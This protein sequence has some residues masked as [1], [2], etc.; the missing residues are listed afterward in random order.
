MGI[1]DSLPDS[2]TVLAQFNRLVQELLRGTMNRNTFRPWEIE[3]LLDIEG[4]DLRDASKRETLRRYQKAVQ[5]HMERGA[6]LP[7]KLSEYL[8]AQK[9][10]RQQVVAS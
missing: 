8:D 4:C 2:E 9:T 5:R 3:I 1:I 6:R 10:K 7:L